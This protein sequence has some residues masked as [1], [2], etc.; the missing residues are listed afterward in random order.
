MVAMGLVGT[1]SQIGLEASGIVC[2]VGTGVTG[3]LIGD[4][5]GLVGSGLCQTCINVPARTC[6]KI[7][8]SVSMEVAAS[9]LVPFL[10]A[11]YSLTHAGNLKKGQVRGQTHYAGTENGN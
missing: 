1:K 3:F 8:E 7:P 9:T 2:E 10:T 4:R 5:V 11:L 6:W